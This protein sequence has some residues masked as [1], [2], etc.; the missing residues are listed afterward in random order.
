MIAKSTFQLA[1]IFLTTDFFGSIGK[2]YVVTAVILTIFAG[3]IAF[4][5]LLERRISKLEKEFE[6]DSGN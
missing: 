1:V 4:L 6:N 5:I 3:I 2:I